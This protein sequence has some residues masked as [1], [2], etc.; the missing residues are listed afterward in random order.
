MRL[1]ALEHSQVTLGKSYQL[2]YSNDPLKF[3]LIEG[4]AHGQYCK[5][6]L[7]RYLGPPWD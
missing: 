5:C 2:K 4:V 6:F 3:P 7:L 1:G